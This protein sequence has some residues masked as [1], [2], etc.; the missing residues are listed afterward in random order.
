SSGLEEHLRSMFFATGVDRDAFG[1]QRNRPVPASQHVPSPSTWQCVIRRQA[2]GARTASGRNRATR[3]G[4]SPICPSHP[5]DRELADLV[6][7]LPAGTVGHPLL[8]ISMRPAW[9]PRW[10]FFT[11]TLWP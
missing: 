3:P 7:R 11:S 2:P 9:S 4:T 6:L 1:S 8:S 10:G 5:E